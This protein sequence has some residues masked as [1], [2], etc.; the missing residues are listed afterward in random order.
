MSDTDRQAAREEAQRW[1]AVAIDDVRVAQACLALEP[2][3]PG[4][5]A[6]HCQQ[7]A[8]KVMKGLLVAAGIGFRKTHDLDELADKAGPHYPKLAPALDQCRPLSS[9][10]TDYRYPPE[11]DSPPPSEQEIR[12]AIK[13]LSGLL[14]AVSALS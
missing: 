5:S 7:A 9:W 10:C 8:E 2:P 3:S 6:Y 11:D 12:E 13:V 1:W 4:N 14:E